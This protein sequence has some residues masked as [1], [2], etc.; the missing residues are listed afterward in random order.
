MQTKCDTCPDNAVTQFTLVF[1]V[2][3][4]P[5]CVVKLKAWLHS[6]GRRRAYLR[7]QVRLEQINKLITRNGFVTAPML[8]RVSGVPQKRARNALDY[9]AREGCLVRSQRGV[10]ELPEQQKAAE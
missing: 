6:K 8:A 10:W 4:C 9:M 7:T 1:D 3:I 2:R 5:A